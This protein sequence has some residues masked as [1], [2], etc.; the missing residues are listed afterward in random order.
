VDPVIVHG[1]A[2]RIY[3]A[4][5][6]ILPRRTAGAVHTWHL[7]PQD[8]RLEISVSI[9]NAADI[10]GSG[11]SAEYGADD[12]PR[13]CGVIS[14]RRCSSWVSATGPAVVWRVTPRGRVLDLFPDK[15]LALA[16]EVIE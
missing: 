4:E 16:S 13:A 9:G 6:L 15:L 3:P 14:M 5:H 2:A 12:P 7:E 1:S 8:H 11:A 10:D